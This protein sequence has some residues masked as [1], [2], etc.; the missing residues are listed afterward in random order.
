ME[1]F[2]PGMVPHGD[3]DGSRIW[4]EICT[5]G[6][7]LRLL[8]PLL[9]AC[10]ENRVALVVSWPNRWAVEQPGKPQ[11]FDYLR[12][13]HACYEAFWRLGIGVDVVSPDAELSAY[14][15]VAAPCLYQLTARQAE[16]LR[17]FVHQGGHL[18]TGYFS[19]IV[20]DSERV[21]LGGYPALLQDV[22]GLEVEEWHALPQGRAWPLSDGYGGATFWAEAIHARTA[23]TLA[24][25]EE[26]PLAGRPALLRH[27]FGRGT[28][29]Y[30]GTRL[31][32]ENFQTYVATI[33]ADCGLAAPI[34]IPQGVEQV[35]RRIASR[36][37]HFVINHLE[38]PTAIGLGKHSY[39]ELL[40]GETRTGDGHELAPAG[41]WI[42]EVARQK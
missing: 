3:V 33:A 4:S 22:L 20:D 31:D 41:V 25:F 14:G 2:L 5:L 30:F 15:A 18:L 23:Q 35:F 8:A 36:E 24:R 6:A 19:G 28:S 32:T 17:G 9:G 21:H 10:H 40:T 34:V 37:V 26:G 16:A 29:W 1:K 11:A 42:L 12:E 38:T 39:R 27:P 7:E 13:V